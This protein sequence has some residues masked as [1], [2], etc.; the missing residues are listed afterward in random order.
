MKKIMAIALFAGA[1]LGFGSLAAEAS[2]LPA[3]GSA[4][5]TVADAS[6]AG[7]VDQVWYRRHHH[8]R[9]FVVVVP[10]YYGYRRWR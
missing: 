1:S 3:I 6:K 9:H 8:R 5:K 4:A 7:V 2:V 10:R